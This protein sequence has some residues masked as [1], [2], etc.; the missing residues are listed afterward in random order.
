M[1]TRKKYRYIRMVMVKTIFDKVSEIFGLI[2]LA[3][4]FLIYCHDL[5]IFCWH[6]PHLDA[7]RLTGWGKH[8][9]LKTSILQMQHG[10]EH[11][12]RMV[13]RRKPFSICHRE[14]GLLCTHNKNLEV[15]IRIGGIKMEWRKIRYA[16][17]GDHER[18]IGWAE[19]TITCGIGGESK[20]FP[21]H[22][23]HI[24]LL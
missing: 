2:K 1:S 3:F 6:G 17:C 24:G 20:E 18:E 7:Y 9:K 21:E 5:W 19:R 8:I 13:A 10:Y 4:I 23:H 11:F 12:N 15:F 22:M 14:L 16:G